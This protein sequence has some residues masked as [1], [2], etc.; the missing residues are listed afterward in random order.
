[1]R[2]MSIPP[3]G[4][5]IEILDFDFFIRSRLQR[6]SEAPT[7]WSIRS[8]PPGIVRRSSEANCVVSLGG[9]A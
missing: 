3:F 8:F 5:E 7:L 6:S 2:F 9:N 1:M 4:R